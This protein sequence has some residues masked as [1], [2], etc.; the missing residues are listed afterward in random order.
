MRPCPVVRPLSWARL[1][2]WGSR[3]LPRA[4]T[5]LSF[6]GTPSTGE[7]FDGERVLLFVSRIES[8]FRLAVVGI[9]AGRAIF[10]ICL[11]GSRSEAERVGM[12]MIVQGHQMRMGMMHSKVRVKKF[13]K[14]KKWAF[15]G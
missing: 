13:K 7:E 11:R 12:G 4:V 14:F 1:L 9:V 5:P 2:R 8:L 6:T 10:E 3:V 15:C